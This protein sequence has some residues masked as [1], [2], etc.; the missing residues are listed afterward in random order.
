[1]WGAVFKTEP[2]M[3]AGANCVWGS[4]WAPTEGHVV[5]PLRNLN[6]SLV[7]LRVLDYDFGQRDDL[8]GECLVDVDALLAMPGQ[9]ASLPLYRKQGLLG[10]YGPQIVHGQPSMVTLCALPEPPAEGVP[11]DFACQGMRRVRICLVSASNLRSGDTFSS[12]DVFCKLWEV[13]GSAQQGRPLPE[14]P[15]RVTMPQARAISFPFSFLLPANLPSTQEDVPDLDWGFVRCSVYAHIDVAWRL[16]PSV[17]AFISIVQPVPASLPRLLMPVSASGSKPVFGV[18]CDCCPEE[19]LLCFG[20]ACCENKSDPQGD[21]TLEVS[22]LRSGMAPGE[23]VPFARLRA[24]NGTARPSV[25]RIQFVRYFAITAYAIAASITADEEI[26]VFE[27]PVAPGADVSLTPEVLVP[28]LSPDYHGWG[29]SQSPYPASFRNWGA[30]WTAREE[31]LRW[32]TELR[33][34]LDTPGTPFDLTHNLPVFIAALPPMMSPLAMAPAAGQYMN[35]APTHVDG[36]CVRVSAEEL[37]GANL[38]AAT[39]ASQEGVF[40][41]DEEEDRHCDKSTLTLAPTYFVVVSPVP[42]FTPSPYCG[43]AVDVSACPPGGVA[44]CPKTGKTFVVPYCA[45]KGKKKKKSRDDD[46]DD[47]DDEE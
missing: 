15:S 28:L 26:T 20:T 45:G 41:Q 34:I 11:A 38:A 27:A 37:R 19:C 18:H 3:N 8:L 35:T 36:Y 17:R 39:T 4:I 46:D 12:N 5:M 24:V 29:D 32:R 43:V 47:D 13:D 2:V 10:H 16:N 40:A 14:P 33:V 31:P 7:A 30:R 6:G 25:L 23:L 42:R 21:V 44:T 9:I 1:M 22:L